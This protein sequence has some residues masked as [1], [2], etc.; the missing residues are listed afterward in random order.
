MKQGR[1]KNI[2][3]I[4]KN[5]KIKT[6]GVEIDLTEE[7]LQKLQQSVEPK[8]K[9]PFDRVKKGEKYYYVVMSSGR[10]RTFMNIEEFTDADN[11][12][13]ITGNYYNNKE[14]IKQITMDLNLRQLLMK[15]VYDKGYRDSL[16]ENT[17]KNKY[18]IVFNTDTDSKQWIYTSHCHYCNPF[19]VYF[20][21]IETAKRAIEE[22]VKPFCKAN[23]SYRFQEK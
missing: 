20:K 2:E 16:W 6:H 3:N 5:K 21:D 8:Y 14:F 11:E 22:V 15:F 12:R 1:I 7:Q 10:F 19:G 4:L 23:P 18:S 17:I 9:H 13:F